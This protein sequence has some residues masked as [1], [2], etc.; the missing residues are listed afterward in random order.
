[1]GVDIKII[2][3]ISYIVLKMGKCDFEIKIVNTLI[4]IDWEYAFCH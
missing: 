1:M 4:G 2:P 3:M